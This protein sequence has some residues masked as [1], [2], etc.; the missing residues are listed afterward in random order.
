MTTMSMR[1]QK[2]GNFGRLNNG[3]HQRKLLSLNSLSQ[4][5]IQQELSTSWNKF[6]SF[7]SLDTSKEMKSPKETLFWLEDQVLPKHPVFWCLQ[8]NSMRNKPSRESISQVLP[9]QVTFKNPLN[10]KLRRNK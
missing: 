6:L 9:F 5:V 4:L 8:T 1:L 3:F 10:L 2:N 7:R